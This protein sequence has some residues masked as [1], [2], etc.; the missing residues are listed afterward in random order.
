MWRSWRCAEEVK[1][2]SLC[3]WSRR[4]C[5][6]VLM[7]VGMIVPEHLQLGEMTF[8]EI[9]AGGTDTVYTTGIIG[10]AQNGA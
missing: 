5:Q 8:I 6:F 1:I 7:Q 4:I 2:S 3:R 10:N 9:S